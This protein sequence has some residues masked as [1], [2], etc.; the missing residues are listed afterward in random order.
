MKLGMINLMK[1]VSPIFEHQMKSSFNELS[2]E[3]MQDKLKE[4]RSRSR[5]FT[6]INAKN[7]D[8][9]GKR[10]EIMSE[11][12]VDIV[13]QRMKRGYSVHTDMMADVMSQPDPHPNINTDR[14]TIEMNHELGKSQPVP[15]LGLKNSLVTK[16]HDNGSF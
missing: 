8:T 7:L 9:D 1:T 2:S 13:T 3:Y 14:E 11:R 16:T 4:T 12:N 10:S 6:K 15:K 5:A